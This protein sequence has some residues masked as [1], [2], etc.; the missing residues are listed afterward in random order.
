MAF[1]LLQ[2]LAVA[3]TAG[4]PRGWRSAPWVA[5]TVAF[6]LATS[7]LFFASLDEVVPF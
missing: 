5:G 1:F 7:A 4:P 3:A 6:N 2:G